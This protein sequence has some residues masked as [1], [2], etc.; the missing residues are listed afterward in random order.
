MCSYWNK[1]YKSKLIA[2]E[3]STQREGLTTTISF[4][5]PSVYTQQKCEDMVWKHNIIAYKILHEQP[6]CEGI[7]TVNKFTNC[8]I[9]TLLTNLA[10]HDKKVVA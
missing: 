2:S 10:F 5:I 8:H 6:Y 7:L 9:I 4:D 3:N 1:N